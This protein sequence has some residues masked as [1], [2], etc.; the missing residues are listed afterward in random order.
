MRR[1]LI[2]TK[3]LEFLQSSKHVSAA[4]ESLSH[5]TMAHFAC[6][7]PPIAR[8]PRCGYAF[9]VRCYTTSSTTP[10][11]T[12]AY[13]I[14]QRP[15]CQAVSYATTRQALRGVAKRAT[16]QR[17]PKLGYWG[18]RLWWRRSNCWRCGATLVWATL[19]AIPN[20]RG[21]LSHRRSS[22]Y[23][24]AP[25]FGPCWQRCQGCCCHDRLLR[26]ATCAYIGPVFPPTLTS[27]APPSAGTACGFS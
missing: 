16:R 22:P 12:R 2:I 9:A 4:T 27:F 26:F 5:H 23:R 21:S 1:F 15:A 7:C 18:R 14:G 20:V 11:S 8:A 3:R 19:L 17:R 13:G 24:E 25:P 6:W 10:R